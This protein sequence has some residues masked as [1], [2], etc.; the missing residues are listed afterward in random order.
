MNESYNIIK[1]KLYDELSEFKYKYKLYDAKRF[2][3]LKIKP[4]MLD[5][6]KGVKSEEILTPELKNDIEFFN[7]K[8]LKIDSL[9]KPLYLNNIESYKFVLVDKINK[10]NAPFEKV[11]GFTPTD[12][13]IITLTKGYNK[14]SFFH[15]L[16]HLS[17]KV[18]N[19]N[20]VFCGL[21][22]YDFKSGRSVG[23]YF[24]EGYTQ[25]LNRRYFNDTRDNVYPFETLIASNLER[26]I[27]VDKMEEN[28][29]NFN[30]KGLSQ[31]IEKY[32]IKEKEFAKFLFNIDWCHDHLFY[33]KKL[34]ELEKR[35]FIKFMREINNF[36]IEICVCKYAISCQTREEYD[37]NLNEVFYFINSITTEIT[38]DNQSY[39]LID[40]DFLNQIIE[41]KASEKYYSESNNER[42][43]RIS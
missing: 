25:V 30:L 35:Q 16:L 21:S 4:A 9:N 7:N 42:Y 12:G 15:E 19:G 10:E 33:V 23:R 20:I 31:E 11:I 41:K 14:N 32:G 29:F 6:E 34:G 39:S 24:N 1:L 5:Y 18:K 37:Q 43:K 38:F 2:S 13:R 3:C 28:Y 40:N 36:L 26:L 27:G 22:Q 8:V 17:T